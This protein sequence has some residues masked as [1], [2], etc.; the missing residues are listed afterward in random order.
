[1]LLEC[2][3]EVLKG[4][5]C[6]SHFI[7]NGL[8]IPTEHGRIWGGVRHPT[9]QTITY[10]PMRRTVNRAGEVHGIINTAPE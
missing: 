5:A 3:L 9:I 2:I 7:Y 10:G 4:L 8:T 6:V 1:M